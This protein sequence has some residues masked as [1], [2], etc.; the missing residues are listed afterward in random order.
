MERAGSAAT[1]IAAAAA[2]AITAALQKVETGPNDGTHVRKLLRSLPLF[3]GNLIDVIA[4][5]IRVALQ[6]TMIHT[7]KPLHLDFQPTKQTDSDTRARRGEDVRH[8]RQNSESDR[9]EGDNGHDWSSSRRYRIRDRDFGRSN[10][11]YHGSWQRSPNRGNYDQDE[12]HC[13]RHDRHCSKRRDRSH[14]RD[15]RKVK[16]RSWKSK[17]TTED[18]KRSQLSVSPEYRPQSPQD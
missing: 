8:R 2:A 15:D 1:I 5:H 9:P 6:T 17:S 16:Q 3:L 18:R 11:R 12:R 14:E 7:E 10:E 4:S 13:D